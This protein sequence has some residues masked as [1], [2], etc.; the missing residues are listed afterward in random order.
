[1]KFAATRPARRRLAAGAVAAAAALLGVTGCSAVSPVATGI[2]YS[3]SDGVNGS[4]EGFIR[5]SNLLLVGAGDS[6]PARLIGSLENPSDQDMAYT[7]TTPTGGSATVDVPA[8][9]TVVLE[10]QDIALERKDAWVGELLPVVI[11]GQGFETEARVPLMS[12]TQEQY[13]D[14]LPEGVSPSDEELEGHL[15]EESLHYGEGH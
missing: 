2:Q 12:A 4:A 15:H 11:K 9:E 7:F 5:Y 10:D 6:G 1:M 8:G 13:R 14:L 3:A